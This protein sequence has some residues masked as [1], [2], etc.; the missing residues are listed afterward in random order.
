M[1]QQGANWM[2]EQMSFSQGGNNGRALV[3]GK[4]LEFLIICFEL[5]LA[6]ASNR[7]WGRTSC[8]DIGHT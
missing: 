6:A 3:C 8:G 4:A 2:S 1:S 5:L 7:P